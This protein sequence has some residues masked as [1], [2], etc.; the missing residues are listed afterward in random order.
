GYRCWG[1]GQRGGP[2]T[3]VA[4]APQLLQRG[5]L[6]AEAVLRG[7]AG[8]R[9]G[10]RRGHELLD[11]AEQSARVPAAA[12]AEDGGGGTAAELGLHL[13]Q[14]TQRLQQR[15]PGHRLSARRE[16]AGAP[17]PP[18]DHPFLVPPLQKGCG[19]I[20][21]SPAEGEADGTGVI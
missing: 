4:V 17:P 10:P 18:M 5:A 14:A 3:D 8:G 11:G 9:P 6:L 15:G 2:V 16:Q 1:G 13:P 21:E 19:Q 12:H 7:A 20:G